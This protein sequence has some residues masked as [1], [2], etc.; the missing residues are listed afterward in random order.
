[1]DGTY[2]YSKT[3]VVSLSDKRIADVSTRPNP[4]NGNFTVSVNMQSTQ[5]VNMSVLNMMGT[6]VWKQ[7]VTTTLGDNTLD[8]QLALPN[9]IY[10]LLL[11]QN[12]ESTS[13][14]IVIVK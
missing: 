9:G 2:T 14:K 11:E 10:M 1:L 8:T 6:T 5:P 13:H 7:T 3:V 12:G 4:S